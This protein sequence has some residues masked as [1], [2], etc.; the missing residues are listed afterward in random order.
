MTIDTT[1]QQP[2]ID[3]TNTGQTTVAVFEDTC[4]NQIQIYQA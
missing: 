2:H 4:G 3:P 1:R